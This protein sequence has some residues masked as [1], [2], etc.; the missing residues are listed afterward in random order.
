[1]VV[2]ARRKLDETVAFFEGMREKLR[3]DAAAQLQCA[4]RQRID[5]RAERLQ[6]IATRQRA[7]ARLQAAWRVVLVS[8]RRTRRVGHQPA[9]IV[10][11]YT[12]ASINMTNAPGA[13]LGSRAAAI[14]APGA[15]AGPI[16][17]SKRAS[18]GERAVLPVE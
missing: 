1:M 5:R 17:H 4:W 7:A 12:V 2:V 14:G 8:R 10:R 3:A 9:G 18:L 16:K 11:R 6:A 13:P 15:G